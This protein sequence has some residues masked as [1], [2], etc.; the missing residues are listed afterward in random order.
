MCS[1]HPLSK[2]STERLTTATRPTIGF[3]T[4]GI[5]NPV[6]S[7]LWSGVVDAARQYHVNLLCF[8]GESLQSPHGYKSLANVIYEL[9]GP[10]HVDGLIFWNSALS[11]YVKREEFARFRARFHPLP[12][13]DVE[14]SPADLTE[15][16]SYH[17]MRVAV[18]HLIEQHDCRRIA[19]IRGPE[20][21]CEAEYRYQA[22]C[23]ALRD[24]Q[25]PFDPHL[26]TPAGRWAQEWGAEAMH[27]LLDVRNVRFDA[28]AAPSDLL[29]VSAI[30]ALQ[31]RNIHVP[32]EVAV[33]GIDDSIEG[34][35]ATP[36][37]TTMPYSLYEIGQHGVR[38]LLAQITGQTHVKQE[39][40]SSDL[41]IRQSCGCLPPSVAQ[42]A[43][44]TIIRIEEPLIEAVRKHREDILAEMAQALDQMVSARMLAGQ[45]F[46]AFVAEIEE[47][48][49]G[50][51]LSALDESLRHTIRA[52]EPSSLWQG[53]I[54][55]LS[56]RLLPYLCG[57]EKLLQAEDL[58]QQ[59]RVMIG[60]AEQRVQ[61]CKRLEKDAQTQIMRKISA[62]LI[63]T[64]DV[65]KLMDILA[66]ELP[67]LGIMNCCVSVY[68]RP[69]QPTTNARLILAYDEHG[70]ID[71]EPEQQGFPSQQLVP[72]GLL[73]RQSRYS[74]VL[75]PLYFEQHLGMALFEIGPA[76]GSIYGV[77]SGQISSALQGA[78]LV[79]RVQEH[80]AEISRQQYI[81]STFM[82]TV[83]DSIYF[84]DCE[85]RIT[86]ANKAHAARIGVDD[87][88]EEID[89]TDF[90]FFPQEQALSYYRQEQEIIRTG[91]PVMNIEE[92]ILLSDDQKTWALTTKMP[93]RNEHGEIIGIFGI[94]RDITDLK[95]AEQELQQYRSHLEELVR[96]R[97]EEITRINVCLSDEIVERKRVEQALRVSEQQ[98]RLL[99]EN[100]KNG[101]LIVQNGS[102][103]FVN[104]VFAAML[105][106]SVDFILRQKPT[107]FFPK[108]PHIPILSTAFDVEDGN[109]AGS[110]WQIELMT[111]EGM[112]T[113]TEIEHSAII[114]DTQ[115]A[116]L[117]TIRNIHQ[118]K[119]RELRLEEERARLRQENLMFK[120]S[121]RDRFRFGELIGKS[122]A[123]QRVYELIV[124][125]ATS[126]V[127][128]LVYG[129]S[130]T[131]KEL[132]ARTIHQVSG[133]KNYA[134]VP[135]NC[136]SIPETL[137][138]REFF[139][140][141]KGS[142]TG[143]DR[144]RP[145]FF[146]RAH[147]GSLFLD[148]VT[149]LSPGMQAKLLRVLQDGEYT[150]LGSTAPKQA[151]VMIVAATNRDPR[152]EIAEGRLRKDF[153]YR[154]GVI[155]IA[156][157][158]LQERKEDLPLLIEHMLEHYQQK[159]GNFRGASA[160]TILP[161]ELVQSLYKYSWPGN[162]R[163]L[164]NVVQ[165]Y[166][167][168]ND[169]AAI[170]RQIAPSGSLI[171][172][173]QMK[174]GFRGEQHFGESLTDAL[175][176]LEKQMILQTLAQTGNNTK[177]AAEQLKI[178]LHTLYRRMKKYHIPL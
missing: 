40:F 14:E 8:V 111:N 124:S 43:A 77:L 116:I 61:G 142:F 112:P 106:Y 52:E 103:V 113:W 16:Y 12:M 172:L 39:G 35:Y 152:E 71:V 60:E 119:L 167:A 49:G 92:E 5:G 36:S 163:E 84:K 135:V 153:F 150:P 70:R 65:K 88:T 82:D 30:N 159:H 158:S 108:H 32:K 90:D 137:F 99:A 17:G 33:V 121:I 45:V 38:R 117:L 57:R 134:F 168:T 129:E 97:T 13:V 80:M 122:P 148:E 178:P 118:S 91:K 18:S 3:I 44:R 123:M 141:R 9:V 157:P 55:A 109:S 166:L 46:D 1:K 2:N 146:D 23:D 81:L 130:G 120:S 126:D 21:N 51:F 62:R 162:V 10:H 145:G 87:P 132:I 7:N 101:V 15:S 128:V 27:L 89:K 154:I 41:I 110:P 138:E 93:L 83:P 161:A 131:G 63:S 64:F 4:S 28:L 72:K 95:R 144:D 50:S 59:A 102:I 20:G 127:N 151:D 6:S 25:I 29:A 171:S 114:W 125:A 34:R 143:A 94:S 24:A 173:P 68:E 149:E 155:E 56:R 177:L 86:T 42:A 67:R 47:S 165:R 96:E 174:E 73:A 19:F 170:L 75:M 48:A 54:S 37:L 104:T 139:G 107:A 140:H 66:E 22:Y 115:P 169:L 175:A 133:R 58:W 136:A 156:V 76:E 31:A 100:V 85:G 78:L 98:Y 53:A 105:G 147:R 160:Q 11:N 176:H 26:V 164:Q 74:M 79:Q 69:E